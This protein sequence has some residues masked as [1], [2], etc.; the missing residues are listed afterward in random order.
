MIKAL[1]FD[2]D[3]TLVSFNTHVIPDSAID[4]LSEAH[5]KGIKVFIATGRPKAI[6]NNMSQLDNKGIIDG[7]VTMNGAYCFVGDKMIFS[8]PIPHDSVVAIGNYA[9]KKN[10]ACIFVPAKGI[11]VCNPDD[12]LKEIFYENLHVDNMPVVSF[13][14][15]WKDDIYQITPFFTVEQEAEALKYAPGV[16]GNRWHPGFTDITAVG[17]EKS[18]G[19]QMMAAHFGIKQNE[20]ICFGDGG[21]DI[22]MLEYAGI[23]VALGNANANVKGHADFVTTHIDE[24]GV[25]NALKHFNLI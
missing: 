22:S 12:F 2:I 8:H 13:E 25:A 24:D 18:K 16:M 19:V 3:G 21:N 1:F 10:I 9:R 15:G 20:I 11:R 7:Y 23:G 5:N 17:I 14:D 6:I 4:A